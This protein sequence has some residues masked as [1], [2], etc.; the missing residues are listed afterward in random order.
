MKKERKQRRDAAIRAV[1]NAL[2]K[3][4]VMYYYS[5]VEHMVLIVQPNTPEMYLSLKSQ[6]DNWGYTL[7]SYRFA[8]TP[9]WYT[10]RR[11]DF[12][13]WLKNPCTLV[14]TMPFGKFKGKPL[15][16]MLGTNRGYLEWLYKQESVAARLRYT[17]ALL[18]GE[19]VLPLYA[20]NSSPLPLTPVELTTDD[21]PL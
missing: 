13:D 12:F 8:G 17:L 3:H 21:D 9:L 20:S 18:L 4:R 2:R 16:D 19:D 15:T 5:D 6:S 10:V 7:Y 14:E 11:D 1:E